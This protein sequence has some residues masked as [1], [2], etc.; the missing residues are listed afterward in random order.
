MGGGVGQEIDDEWFLSATVSRA[1][2]STMELYRVDSAA[3]SAA[4]RG[5]FFAP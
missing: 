5:G 4:F 3:S 1:S 2:G